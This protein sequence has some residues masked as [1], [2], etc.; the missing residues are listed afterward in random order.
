MDLAFNLLLHIVLFEILWLV[1][2]LSQYFPILHTYHLLYLMVLTLP[3]LFH[4]LFVKNR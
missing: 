1:I 4:S 3:T 2:L